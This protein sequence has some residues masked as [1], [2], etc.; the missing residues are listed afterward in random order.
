MDNARAQVRQAEAALRLAR[1]NTTQDLLKQQDIQ[2]ARE[3]GRRT[4]CQNNL[5][6]IGLALHQYE[7]THQGFPPAKIYS[8]HKTPT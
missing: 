5:K 2:Q 4:Q 1:G 6:Q 3:A 8:T 7:G